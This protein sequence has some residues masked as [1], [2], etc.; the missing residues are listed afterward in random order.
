M[1]S[2]NDFQRWLRL[3]A[4]SQHALPMAPFGYW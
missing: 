2:V 3:A 1:T 4:A